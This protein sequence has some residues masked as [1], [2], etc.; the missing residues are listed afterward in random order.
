MGD[1]AATMPPP[2][3]DWNICLS[4]AGNICGARGYNVLEQS[5]ERGVLVIQC[6]G[7]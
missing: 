3:P 4:Q 1:A 6:K 5:P 7:Q 2:Q